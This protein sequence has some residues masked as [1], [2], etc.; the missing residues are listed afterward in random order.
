M[1][2]SAKHLEISIAKMRH[3]LIGWKDSDNDFVVDISF[4]QED[5]G[6]GVMIDCFTLKAT[7]PTVEGEDIEV[8]MEVELYPESEKLDPRVSKIES[9]KI[10]RKY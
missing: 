4:T 9:F 3:S 1:K 8:R 2:I 6:G 5:P 10:M 7:K